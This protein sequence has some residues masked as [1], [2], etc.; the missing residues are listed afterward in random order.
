[1]DFKQKYPSYPDP[2][3]PI[4]CNANNYRD[5]NDPTQCIGELEFCNDQNV[6]EWSYDT[7]TTINY[8][9]D[10]SQTT[11]EG[12]C[13]GCTSDQDNLKYLQLENGSYSCTDLENYDYVTNNSVTTCPV[14]SY[15]SD[16]RL[17]CVEL[18]AL[19]QS[20]FTRDDWKALYKERVDRR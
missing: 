14:G 3:N 15:V 17:H 16:D 20:N 6:P 19:I 1:M 10:T 2:S 4:N 7:E 9:S 13:A 11:K 12:L 18:E 8:V 5:P